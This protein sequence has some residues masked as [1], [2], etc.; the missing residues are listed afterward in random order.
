MVY[1]AWHIRI[2]SMSPWRLVG[3]LR[4]ISIIPYCS[5]SNGGMFNWIIDHV[6]EG[7]P[8][9]IALQ[10]FS[11]ADAHLTSLVGGIRFPTIM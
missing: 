11:H 9:R 5:S 2:F 1:M 6:G 10:G 4:A 7:S 8:V 3:L